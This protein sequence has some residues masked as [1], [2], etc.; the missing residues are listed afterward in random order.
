MGCP[1]L[2]TRREVRAQPRAQARVGR[3][4]MHDV[5]I[6]KRCRIMTKKAFLPYAYSFPPETDRYSPPPTLP[7]FSLLVARPLSLLAIPFLVVTVPLEYVLSLRSDLHRTRPTFP[8]VRPTRICTRPARRVH[9]FVD[10]QAVVQRSLIGRV[11]RYR[12]SRRGPLVRCRSDAGFGRRRGEG[13]RVV[14]VCTQM[15]GV[16]VDDDDEVDLRSTRADK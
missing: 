15:S 16:R 3:R 7:S 13:E 4:W 11:R 10:G 1:R 5:F 12:R 14:G 6:I 9:R 8:P 2:S